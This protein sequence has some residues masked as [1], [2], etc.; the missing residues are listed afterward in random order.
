M[1]RNYNLI[2]D[3]RAIK[4]AVEYLSVHN[5][6]VH[7]TYDSI[8][9]TI[10]SGAEKNAKNADEDTSHD[11]RWDMSYAG[12]AGYLVLFSLLEYTKKNKFPIIQADVYVTPNIGNHECTIEKIRS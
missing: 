11:G 2:Y 1:G 3:A 10:K 7:I 5:K 6:T 9:A 4:A 8:L 12:T